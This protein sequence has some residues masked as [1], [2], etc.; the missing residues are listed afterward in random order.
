MDD[1]FIIWFE[2][3]LSHLWCKNCYTFTDLF[4]GS[5]CNFC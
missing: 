4:S 2:Y 5:K 1:I 3:P